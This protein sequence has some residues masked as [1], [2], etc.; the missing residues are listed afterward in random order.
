MQTMSRLEVSTAVSTTSNLSKPLQRQHDN[1]RLVVK[2]PQTQSD[3]QTE[4]TPTPTK[5][6]KLDFQ[7]IT[8]TEIRFV[9]SYTVEE[10]LHNI[11]YTTCI[12]GD[13]VA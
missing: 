9:V 1:T 12:S 10:M 3:A 8:K 4:C 6:Q 7:Q 11:K 13:V 2:D 5:Q